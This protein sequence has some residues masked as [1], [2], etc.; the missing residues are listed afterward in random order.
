MRLTHDAAALVE[1][2]KAAAVSVEAHKAGMVL[3][4]TAKLEAEVRAAMEAV[5]I[6]Y[7]MTTAYPSIVTVH[8]KFL[9]NNHYYHSLE[10]GELLLADV[11]AETETGWAADI[12]RTWPVSGKFSST[13]RYIYDI[14]LAAHD[15]YFE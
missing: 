5:I 4:S 1:L 13:Q 6:R 9:H 14:V 10:R 2:R 12:T 11:G 7:N 15:A 8:G 3:T